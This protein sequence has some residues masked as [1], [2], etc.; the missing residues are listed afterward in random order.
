MRKSNA[1][2]TALPGLTATPV[3]LLLPQATELWPRSVL[4]IVKATQAIKEGE[5]PPSMVV[6]LTQQSPRTNYKVSYL[7]SLQANQ[8]L[9]EVA[10]PQTGS[11]LI[12]QDTE[13]L[14]ISPK[15]LPAAYA[16]VIYSGDASKYA[17][18]FDKE[19]DKLRPV[20]V[21]ERAQQQGNN[22][23]TVT[24]EDTA[25]V[26]SSPIAFGT[27][28]SGALVAVEVDENAQFIPLGD[29]DL[30]LTGQLAALSGIQITQYPTR[31]TYGL[32]L[33]FYVPAADSPDKIQLLGYNEHLVRIATR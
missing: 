28:D 4:A 3:Q 33:L 6:V 8:V 29:R 2:I 5:D 7:A 11:Q 25:G 9:P 16:D 1:E 22:E 10:A 21:D 19:S 13:L 30:K 26:L 15:D 20:L 32:Q 24:Y 23:V 17:V 18:L 31:A 27:V 12:A 14:K